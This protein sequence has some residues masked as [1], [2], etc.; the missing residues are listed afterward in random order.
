L[1][2]N[3]SGAGAPDD[4]AAPVVIA[5]LLIANLAFTG[6]ALTK[7]KTGLLGAAG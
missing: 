2:V 6:Q 1:P 5:S 3:R 7:A 4:L